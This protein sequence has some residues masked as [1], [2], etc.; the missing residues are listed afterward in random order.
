MPAGNGFKF[1][2]SICAAMFAIGLPIG[3]TLPSFCLGHS[4]LVTS[5]DASVGP[6]RLCSC[7]GSRSKNRSTSSFFKAS[8]LHITRFSPLQLPVPTPSKYTCSIEGTKYTVVIFSLSM[9]LIKYETSLCPPGCAITS[10]EPLIKGQK[11]S[12]TDTSKV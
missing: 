1:L 11:N 9:S 4:Q 3:T 7:P 5:T 2:S 12:H 6:Y 10:R 8:P